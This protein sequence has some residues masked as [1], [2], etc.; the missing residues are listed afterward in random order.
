MTAIVP[1]HQAQT[2]VSTNFLLAETV[3]VGDVPEYYTDIADGN[4]FS[5]QSA[6][7]P[8]QLDIDTL[9]KNGLT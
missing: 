4:G 2:T 7:L 3:I 9:R 1:L 8:D 6:D 5:G